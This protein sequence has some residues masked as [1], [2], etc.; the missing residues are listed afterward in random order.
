MLVNKDGK[1][2]MLKWENEELKRLMDKYAY[3]L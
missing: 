3:D 2:E 1:N